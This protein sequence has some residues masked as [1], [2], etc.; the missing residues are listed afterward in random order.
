[1]K[2]AKLV[3][4]AAMA[5]ATAGAQAATVNVQW[6][7]PKEYRDIRAV[8]SSQQRF[9]ERVIEELEEEFRDEA[10]KLPADQT[11]NISVK[12]VNLAGEV[13]YFYRDYPFGL[14]VIRNVDFPQLELS[15]ELRDANDQVIQSGDETLQDLGFRF[16]A[17]T[18]ADRSTLRYEKAL[19]HEWYQQSF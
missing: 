15:Y 5:L 9:E 10:A 1:M 2:R 16:D 19:I 3:F 12:D 8:Q 6:N 17:P 4:I 18:R 7:D 14:R 13:E 11:L